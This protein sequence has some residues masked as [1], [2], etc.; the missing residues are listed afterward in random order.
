MSA[1]SL[2]FLALQ[3]PRAIVLGAPLFGAGDSIQ[4]SCGQGTKIK[5]NS[6]TDTMHRVLELRREQRAGESKKD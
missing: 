4:T 1:G 5:E 6:R 2:F 3:P